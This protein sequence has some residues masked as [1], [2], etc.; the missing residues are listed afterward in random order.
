VEGHVLAV[1]IAFEELGP[2]HLRGLQV[3]AEEDRAVLVVGH[4]E[5]MLRALASSAGAL[6]A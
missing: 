6:L 3:L 2:G 5:D 4:P 1:R